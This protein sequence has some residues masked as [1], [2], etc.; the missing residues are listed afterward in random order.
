M[1]RCRLALQIVFKVLFDAEFGNQVRQLLNRT[2]SIQDEPAP[3]ASPAAE[4]PPPATPTRSEALTL[5]EAL[6]RE[7]RLIDFLQEDITGYQDAQIGAAVREI[8]RGCGDVI[9]RC[10]DVVAVVEQAEGQPFEVTA[11][12]DTAAVRLTG[13]VP[14]TRPVTGVLV[15]SGWRAKKCALPQWTGSEQSARILAPAEVEVN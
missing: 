12:I 2:S 8:H 13:N 15:H 11:E 3:A 7:G 5:L 10:F 4:P 9:K 6:Q 1:G 14:Q